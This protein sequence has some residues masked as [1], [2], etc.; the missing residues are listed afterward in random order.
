[1]HQ[2]YA[3]EPAPGESAAR[4]VQLAARELTG[5]EAVL[6]R[7]RLLEQAA[8]VS[9][10]RFGI[11]ELDAAIY[12]GVEGALRSGKDSQGREFYTTGEML[13]LEAGN[14]EKVRALA[15]TPYLA[16]AMK[17]EMDGFRERL[18]LEGV[19]PT[20]GQWDEFVNEAGGWSSFT[21]S[22]GDP[23]T[24]KATTLGFIECFCGEVLEPE[25]RRPYSVNLACTGKA[26]REMSLA[27]GR[28]AFTLDSFLSQYVASKF[29]LQR[30]KTESP[31]VEPSSERVLIPDGVPVVIRL[32]EASLLGARQARDLL[33]V[34]E[35]L[36]EKGVQVKLHLLGDTK[37]MQAI[38]PGT[39]CVSAGIGRVRRGG[40]CPFNR[41][42]PAE[43]NL[44]AGGCPVPEPGGLAA[45]GER[46]GGGALPGR[47]G[48]R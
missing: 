12:A 30:E 2:R 26:A 21:L 31:I 29:D 3:S 40:L 42:P 39:C 43:G 38:R 37:Q 41:H 10:L 32:D 28:P 1:M 48:C 18:A 46:E 36:R 33:Q 47:S 17:T 7:G 20:A 4:M 23:G 6:E 14:L 8:R 27:T 9:G 22:V 25:G 16:A 15:M 45:G 5:R 35:G 24:A 11:G 34:V 44:A 19:R 13:E